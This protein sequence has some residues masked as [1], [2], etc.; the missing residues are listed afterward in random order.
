[1]WSGVGEGGSVREFM[2]ERRKFV[3]VVNNIFLLK[4][5]R[6]LLLLLLLLLLSRFTCV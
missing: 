3:F 5:R 2:R 4:I 1:M 6:L